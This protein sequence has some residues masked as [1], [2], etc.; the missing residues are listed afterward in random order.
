MNQWRFIYILT[1]RIKEGKNQLIF[2]CQSSLNSTI[3]LNRKQFSI[4]RLPSFD[5]FTNEKTNKKKNQ[6]F[7]STAF[8]TGGVDQLKSVLVRLIVSFLAAKLSSSSLLVSSSITFHRHYYYFNRLFSFFFIHFS[9]HYF[10][11]MF[12][13]LRSLIHS[14]FIFFFYCMKTIFFSSNKLAK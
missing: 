9:R 5:C 14:L 12:T 2:Y 7:F 10:Q 6:F 3:K 1:G 4:Q 13:C 8:L 11:R